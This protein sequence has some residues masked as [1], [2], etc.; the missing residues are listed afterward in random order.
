MNVNQVIK[1]YKEHSMVNIDVNNINFSYSLSKDICDICKKYMYDND[2]SMIVL[3]L[4]FV[5]KYIWSIHKDHVCDSS[6]VENIIEK[7]R[8]IKDDINSLSAK[9]IKSN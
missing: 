6:Y 2:M 1:T 4:I 9:K 5:Q 3:W 8:K 7:I